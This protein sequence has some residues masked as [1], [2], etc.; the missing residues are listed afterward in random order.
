LSLY[1]SPIPGSA[2][3]SALL[4]VLMSSSGLAG[5]LVVVADLAGAAVVAFACS[6]LVAGAVLAGAD[7][8]GVCAMADAPS[9]PITTRDKRPA[10]NRF[11]YLLR[12]RAWTDAPPCPRGDGRV[13]RHCPGARADGDRQ[14]RELMSWDSR[15][16]GGIECCSRSAARD[17][18]RRTRSA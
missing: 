5:V 18:R 1:A 7:P 2:A 10:T 8:D 15:T 17:S 13:V 9:A 14:S 12:V 4:A 3:R 6:V 16:E 11:M